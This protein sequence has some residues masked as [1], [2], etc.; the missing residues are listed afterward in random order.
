M[1]R[2]RGREGRFGRD[3]V[4]GHARSIVVTL[5]DYSRLWRVNCCFV[6]SSYTVC[7]TVCFCECTHCRAASSQLWRLH[8][9]FDSDIIALDPVTCDSMVIACMVMPRVLSVD[10]RISERFLSELVPWVPCDR[11]VVTIRSNT[12]FH[13]SILRLLHGLRSLMEACK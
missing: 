4:A 8:A 6:V 11:L 13:C 5:G 7:N 2:R 12:K 10:T 3:R 9:R 1:G